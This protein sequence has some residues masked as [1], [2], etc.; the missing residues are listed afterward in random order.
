MQSRFI[1]V[2][3]CDLIGIANTGVIM[4]HCGSELWMVAFYGF[5]RKASR[6]RPLY[7]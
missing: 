4:L 1:G 7:R 3:L 5:R 2:K 6:A